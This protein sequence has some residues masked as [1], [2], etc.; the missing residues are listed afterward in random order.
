MIRIAWGIT[1]CGDKIE[2][3]VNTMIELKNELH[4][5]I[6]VYASKSAKRVLKWYK[7][8]DKLID[9]FQEIK[10]EVDANAP[11]LAGKLQTG[12]YHIF[13]VAPATANTVAKIAHCI[14]DT[15]ITNAVSQGVKGGVPV[16]IFP[17]DNR[18][19]EIETV[20][21]GGKTLKLRIRK[22][23]VENVNK[24]RMMEGITVLDTVEDIRRTILEYI[25]SN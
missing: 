21:P 3:V 16:Y 6:D 8:W 10:V 13:L 24:L 4:L 2:E 23:D 19:G 20:I 15:L 12:K 17:P 18:V 22:E 9:E 25:R 5:D 11:F 14:A 1:G 7:L